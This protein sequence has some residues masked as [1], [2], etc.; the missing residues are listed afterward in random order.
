M[1][2]GSQRA[3]VASS[4]SS[5]D[6]HSDEEVPLALCGERSDRFQFAWK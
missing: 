1:A 2:I 3:G 5:E 6:S 4:G